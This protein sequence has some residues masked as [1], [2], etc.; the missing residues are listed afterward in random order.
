[1]TDLEPAEAREIMVYLIE[2][3]QIE[4]VEVVNG[5]DPHEFQDASAP[6]GSNTEEE[7]R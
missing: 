7:M 5:E 1:M 6:H 4:G 2:S 3:G